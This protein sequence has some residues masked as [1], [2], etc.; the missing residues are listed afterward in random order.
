LAVSKD[1]KVKTE[2]PVIIVG[3]SPIEKLGEGKIQL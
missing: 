2:I 3:E 1:E